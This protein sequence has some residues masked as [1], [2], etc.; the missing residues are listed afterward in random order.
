[1]GYSRNRIAPPVVL[2]AARAVGV[3]VAMALERYYASSRGSIPALAL[4]NKWLT[5]VLSRS[6][7]LF[8]L[9]ILLLRRDTTSFFACSLDHR[10]L[11]NDHGRG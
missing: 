3:T 7:L 1:L 2:D 6:A 10:R 11:A 8:L 9:R 4:D 5:F